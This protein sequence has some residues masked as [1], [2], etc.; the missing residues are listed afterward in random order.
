M[1]FSCASTKKSIQT[2]KQESF[3]QSNESQF[4]VVE[5]RIDTTKKENSKITIT[6]IE[7]YPPFVVNDIADTTNM[8]TNNI[9]NLS[10]V[11]GAIKSIKQTTIEVDSEKKGESKEITSTTTEKN[12]VVA[13]NTENATKVDVTPA[14]DPKRW[15]Y[16]F[17]VLL[18]GVA[19][20]L[21]LKRES[22]L[23]LCNLLAKKQGGL[24]KNG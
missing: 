3:T 7:F 22:T 2:T 12:E 24:V 20:F 21:Y 6:E 14:P 5:K 4:I 16:I 9:S 13:E 15:R 23:F 8:Q 18:I 19:V 17:Y 11:S 1:L 10:N